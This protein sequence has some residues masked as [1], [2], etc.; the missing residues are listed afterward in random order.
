[1]RKSTLLLIIVFTILLFHSKSARS[2]YYTDWEEEDIDV[3][4]IKKS[5]KS[6]TLS[7]DGQEISFILV[8]TDMKS[9]V[10]EVEIADHDNDI[11]E[12]KYTDYYVKF[13]GYYGYAGYG[14][15]GILVVGTSSWSSSFYKK[16]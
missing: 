6:G 11:Y 14:E 10:Y 15:E 4:Y 16:P 3:F 2:Q 7:E 1:M 12:I 5:V 13:R 8:P 9:G